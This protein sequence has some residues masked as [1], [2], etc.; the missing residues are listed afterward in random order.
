MNISRVLLASNVLLMGI[1][2]CTMP[3]AQAS[4]LAVTIT[5]QALLLQG[6]SGTPA[7]PTTPAA[8][9]TD[10]SSVPQVSVTSVTNCRTGPSTAY[11]LVF[12]A[13][14]GPAYQIVGKN[15]PNNYWIIDN[16]TGGT[17]WLWGQYAVL[18][19]NTGGLPEY[20]PPPT[21]T[22][23]FT[24]TPKPTFTP[25]TFSL[26]TFILLLPPPAPGS[27]SDTRDCA[28]AFHGVIPIWV[29]SVT[30]TWQDNAN[31]EDGYRVYKNGSALPP[32]PANS[33]T[34]KIELRYQQGT[35]GALFDNFGVEAFNGAG[36]SAR[37]SV[38]VP[39]CP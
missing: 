32:L 38:D 12:S 4:D 31:N 10:T 39:T 22:A 2:A 16:P 27:L 20:A 3:G 18:S 14:P 7:P 13:N 1:L 25:T 30:L 36:A 37:P 9:V 15:T 34:Y 24:R 26:P 11:D 6:P 5:A 8:A 35:G 29:E 21:P 28:G 17:C 23:K 33:T 19:G